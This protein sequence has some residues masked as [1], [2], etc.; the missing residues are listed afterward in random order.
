M[1]YMKK[2]HSL[3][4]L[5][6]FSQ[7]MCILLGCLRGLVY[8]RVAQRA[9]HHVPDVFFLDAGVSGI[10]AAPHHTG[11]KRQ[12]LLLFLQV[13]YICVK[14][15]CSAHPFYTQYNSENIKYNNMI[16]LF[17]TVVSTLRKSKNKLQWFKDE[18]LEFIQ[19]FK[20]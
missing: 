8:F 10:E 15:A 14:S 20:F 12:V 17:H 13:A 1:L 6:T 18:N 7:S 5:T 2:L 4:Q 11:V 3:C 16:F 9:F 19:V